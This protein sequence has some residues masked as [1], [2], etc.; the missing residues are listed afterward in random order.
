[1]CNR[2]TITK[3]IEELSER[4]SIAN[5]EFYRPRFN[6]APSHL[7]PV[8][9]L[10][11]PD[12]ISFFHWG[13]TPEWSKN[14]SISKKLYTILASE[15]PKKPSFR[16]ALVQHRCLV[17][18]DGFYAWKKISKKGEVPYRFTFPN[19]DIYSIPALYEEYENDKEENVSTF[20]II[21]REANTILASFDKTMPAL[22]KK[23]QE[24]IWLNT[25][26]NEEQLMLLLQNTNSEVLEHYS[27]SP[28]INNID[29]DVPSLITP[30]TPA[31]QFGNYSLFN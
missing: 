27:V 21:L 23:E 19:E 13:V 8:I 22:F 7:L 10:N 31:D 1:M 11:K 2:Y 24:Q 29:K 25:E 18:I 30:S 9:T 6:A 4:F 5:E 15:I 28:E 12:Q 14:K 16:K 3:S 26:N 20:T 17:P